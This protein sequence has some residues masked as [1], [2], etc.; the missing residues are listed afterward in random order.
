VKVLRALMLVAVAGCGF[1]QQDKPEAP[2]VARAG[3][4]LT[5]CG[6]IPTPPTMPTTATPY[7]TWLRTHT[8]L[9]PLTARSA[10]TVVFQ[11]DTNP[12]GFI[13]WGFDVVSGTCLFLVTGDLSTEYE[14]FANKVVHDIGQIRLNNPTFIGEGFSSQTNFP[15]GPPHGVKAHTVAASIYNVQN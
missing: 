14:P 6:T 8:E 7:A 11:D 5:S 3:Q 4:A 12:R 2:K 1:E 13:A 10:Y 15:G 9:Y